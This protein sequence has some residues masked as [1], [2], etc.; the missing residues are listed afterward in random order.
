MGANAYVHLRYGVLVDWDDDLDYDIFDDNQQFSFD[1]C[2]TNAP[3]GANGMIYIE[4]KHWEVDVDDSD[5]VPLTTDDLFITRNKS[6]ELKSFAMSNG[7]TMESEPQWF[8]HTYW[9]V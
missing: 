7:F 3:I 8:L 5:F 6:N 9:S 1:D 4:Q 2:L